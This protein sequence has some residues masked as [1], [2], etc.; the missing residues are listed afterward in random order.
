VRAGGGGVGGRGGGVGCVPSMAHE[1]VLDWKERRHGRAQAHF[2]LDDVRLRGV[3]ARLGG[4]PSDED[5][6]AEEGSGVEDAHAVQPA[7]KQRLVGCVGGEERAG[8]GYK[9]SPEGAKYELTL[10]V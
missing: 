7:K 2:A 9:V 8:G 4:E 5:V 6:Y 10:K 1:G 3:E